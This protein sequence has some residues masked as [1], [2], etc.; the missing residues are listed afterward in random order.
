MLVQS[1]A[2]PRA[3]CSPASVSLT[4]TAQGF[5]RLKIL[6]PADAKG[7]HLDAIAAKTVE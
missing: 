7:S 5:A 1:N 3:K 4:K 6:R 2:R